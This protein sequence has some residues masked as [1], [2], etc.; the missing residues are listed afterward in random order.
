[1]K[2]R[3]LQ[4]KHLVY[5]LMV[6]FNINAAEGL[7]QE[8]SEIIRA[9]LNGVSEA[10]TG[11]E[12]FSIRRDP[13]Q[14]LKEAEDT[15]R[16]GMGSDVTEASAGTPSR[17]IE[18]ARVG[19]CFFEGAIEITEGFKNYLRALWPNPWQRLDDDPCFRLDPKTGDPM[20]RAN[21]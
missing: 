18:S 8:G 3:N 15:Q 21:K 13:Y 19:G 16:S 20:E 11:I 14:Q 2:K 6:C 10:I 4:G 1:M 17:L 9:V 5:V 12:G 7:P